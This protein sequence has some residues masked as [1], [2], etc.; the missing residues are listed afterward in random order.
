MIQATVST[1]LPEFYQQTL[2]FKLILCLFELKLSSLK[3]FEQVN[4]NKKLRN[5][6]N[7]FVITGLCIQIFILYVWS[8]F[9]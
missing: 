3:L 8:E 4:I 7:I 6:N 9:I 5:F 2:L 1:F